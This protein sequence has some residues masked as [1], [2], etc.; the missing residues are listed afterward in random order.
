MEMELPGKKKTVRHPGIAL[1]HARIPGASRHFRAGH[2]LDPG[3][4]GRN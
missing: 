1:V 4:D 2:Q 3:P